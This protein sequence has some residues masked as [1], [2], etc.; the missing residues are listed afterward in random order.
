MNT[1][2]RHFIRNSALALSAGALGLGSVRPARST[3]AGVDLLGSYWTFSGTAVP[4][5]GPEYSSFGFRERAEAL[6]RAGFRGM[7]I[8]HADLEHVLNSHSLG[9]MK[10]ILDD[11]GIV[12]VELE[13]LTDWF[14]DGEPRAASDRQRARLLEAA[15]ALDARHVKVGDFNNTEVTMDRLVEEWAGLCR[16][17]ANHGTRVLFELMPFSMLTTLEA[18]LHMFEGAGAD[19][20]GLILDAWHI[21]KLG[22]PFDE[23]ARIPSRYLLGVELNDG[24]TVTPEGMELH[25]Q[26]VD[27][28]MFCGEG[29][30]DLA[31]LVAAIKRAGFGG[32]W[33]IEV[34]SAELRPQPLE[35]AA[36]KAYRTT[37][38]AVAG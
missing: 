37:L 25:T 31:G 26:T 33:G 2:R 9:E 36:E 8:W 19:N 12:H 6:G 7:G 15:E 4:H 3:P 17:A 29:D 22:I 18:T 27:H 16:D 38:A 23:V 30:F 11:N 14:V 28:R 32:P 21:V 24:L 13:F 5:V 20:G 34:L 1:S 10:R 35:F